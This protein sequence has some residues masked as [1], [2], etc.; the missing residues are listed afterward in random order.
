[1]LLVNR[2]QAAGLKSSLSLS[3]IQLLVCIDDESMILMSLDIDQLVL[4]FLNL[5]GLNSV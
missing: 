2:C 5:S 3:D 4:I 1:M